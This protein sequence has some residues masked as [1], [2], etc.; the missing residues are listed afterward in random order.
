MQEENSTQILTTAK[1]H[2]RS[3]GLSYRMAAPIVGVTYQHLS[4]VLNGHRI[5][6]PLIRRVLDLRPGAKPGDQKE[7]MGLSRRSLAASTR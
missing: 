2:L 1:S 4:L 6:L 5:S 7:R 3:L